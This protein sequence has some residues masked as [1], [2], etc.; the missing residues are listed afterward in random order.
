MRSVHG[1]WLVVAALAVALA[2]PASASALRLTRVAGGFG[3]LTQV[4]APRSGDR[5]GTLYVVEQKGRIWKRRAGRTQLF[6]D[7]R[8]GVRFEGER[9]LLSMAFDPA[10]GKNGRFYVY[11]TNNDGDIVVARYRANSTRTR[12]VASS[13]RRLLRIR[14]PRS[15]HNGGQ[16]AFGPNGRLYAAT[17][18][19]GSGCDPDGNAQRLASRLGKLLSLNPRNIAGGWRR[20]GYGL[21]NPFRFSF[22]RA[23]GRLYIGDVGQDDREEVN[24]RRAGALGGD[25]ENYGWD[26][27]EGREA[28]GCVNEGLTTAGPLVWPISTYGRSLGCSIIGGFAY[29]GGRL[30]ARLRG[31][32]FFGDWCSGKIWRIR[33]SRDGRLVVGRK[34]VRDTSF[35]ITSFGEG[36][37]GELYVATSGGAV[38]RLVRS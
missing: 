15:N 10:Y 36:V 24:T 9:G 20:D 28:S 23:T 4:T 7:I 2:L 27:Y 17:G 11:F 18:D 38:Y 19:G 26:V 13:R 16:L 12:A 3:Q 5:A 25:P 35:N 37:A 33:V 31:S 29:R 6:L 34:L 8:R 22:D 30:P 32:Y 14:H 1:V 21:R